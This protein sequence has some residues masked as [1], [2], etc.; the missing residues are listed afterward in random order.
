[1]GKMGKKRELEP[2]SV[3]SS[4]A[5]VPMQWW[6]WWRWWCHVLRSAVVVGS[7]KTNCRSRLCP[8]PPLSLS[9]QLLLQRRLM[10]QTQNEDQPKSTDFAPSLSRYLLLGWCSVA[11][12]Y[13][14][15]SGL[16]SVL[17]PPLLLLLPH[18]I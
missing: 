12:T 18:P 10:H 9:L 17:P 6:W 3:E 13:G 11:G 7:Y 5:L 16:N 2:V 15:Q 4:L 8:T 1:M 14:E